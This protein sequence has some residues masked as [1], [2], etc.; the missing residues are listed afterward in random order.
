L[1]EK[2]HEFHD[3]CAASQGNWLKFIVTSRPYDD[4]QTHFQPVTESFP[5]IHLRGEE[6]L[7]RSVMKS[8]WL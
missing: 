2:L 3:R 5:H 4:I 7:I 8:A 1:I 6:E